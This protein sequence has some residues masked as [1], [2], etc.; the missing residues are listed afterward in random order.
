MA[1]RLYALYVDGA[2]SLV[3]EFVNVNT[4]GYYARVDDGAKVSIHKASATEIGQWQEVR[5]HQ[6]ETGYFS[7]PGLAL[8]QPEPAIEPASG[9]CAQ[10]GRPLSF[11]PGVL[12]IGCA[13]GAPSPLVI[14]YQRLYADEALTELLSW[15]D[16][17]EMMEQN[18]FYG[19]H[20]KMYWGT[21]D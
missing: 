14:G 13:C 15:E 8:E 12:S 11:G 10:C 3:D 1:T 20:H 21:T 4:A 2:L 17:A 5:Q 7:A 18:T 16:V 19:A 9:V 6:L